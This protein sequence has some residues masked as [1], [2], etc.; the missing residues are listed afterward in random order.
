MRPIFT[1]GRR[2][3]ATLASLALATAVLP[4]TACG[5]TSSGGDD[6]AIKAVAST[7]QICDYIT[8]LAAGG[9]DDGL[10]FDRTGAD[11]ATEHFGADTA[12]ASTHLEL[13]CLLA[14]NASAHEHEMTAAQSKALSEA[15]LFLVSGVDLEHFLDDAVSSTGFKGTMV[16]TSGVYGAVADGLLLGLG[17]AGLYDAARLAGG[18]APTGG[19][20]VATG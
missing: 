16:V 5:S 4:L 15:D 9:Q 10:S 14:P 7:T 11:G 20:H 8:Q 17:A 18:V 6:S 19:R 1:C 3:A 13:T 12:T 2:T